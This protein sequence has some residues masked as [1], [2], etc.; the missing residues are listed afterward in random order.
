MSFVIADKPD[1]LDDEFKRCVG[2][3]LSDANKLIRWYRYLSQ[4]CRS[5]EVV[6]EQV[7][8]IIATV[9]TDDSSLSYK[10]DFHRPLPRPELLNGKQLDQLSISLRRNITPPTAE[11][12][13]LDAQEALAQYRYRETVLLA[14][15][16][17]ET[18]FDPFIRSKL[19][20]RFP[21][22][23]FDRGGAG[24]NIES[25]LYFLTRADVLLS[26]LT[27]FSLRVNTNPP[28]WDNLCASRFHR[29]EIIHR[30]S[31]AGEDEAK[32]AINVA[33]Q[34]IRTINE[35]RNG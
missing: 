13:L 31:D 5:I 2:I 20:E 8:P 26:L 23:N 11:L 29:N 22:L 21:G 28:F 27:G 12:L 34:F 33:Q 18:I 9:F 10:I 3:T 7:S 32:L 25:D 1:S 16:A 17:I 15:S 30:G 24:A 6:R 19:L 14:W 4:D 35:L